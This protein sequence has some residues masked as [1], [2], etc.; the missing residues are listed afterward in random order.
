MW[1]NKRVPKLDVENR[2]NEKKKALEEMR[3]KKIQ[4]SITK[5]NRR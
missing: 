4:N 5:V 3:S 1:H 2:R